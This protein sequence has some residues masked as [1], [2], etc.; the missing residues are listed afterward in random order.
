[1]KIILFFNGGWGLGAIGMILFGLVMTIGVDFKATTLLLISPETGQGTVTN[2][3]FTNQR[4]NRKH[5]R[6]Y[7]YIF[8]SPIGQLKGVSYSLN[9]GRKVGENVEIEYSALFPQV[10][11]IKGLTSSK[12]GS[13]LLPFAGP[14]IGGSIW[15]LYIFLTGFRRISIVSNG[16]L[17]EGTFLNKEATNASVLGKRVYK[18]TF[19][20]MTGYGKQYTVTRKTNSPEKLESTDGKLLIYKRNNPSHARM[21]NILPKPIP[22]FIKEHWRPTAGFRN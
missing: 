19:G 21:I 10:N 14:L 5:I 11:R 1:M 2:T 6:G 4:I 12:G 22:Q 7:E 20:Y 16:I 8:D 9:K 13:H 17:T 18:V 3:I 15:F